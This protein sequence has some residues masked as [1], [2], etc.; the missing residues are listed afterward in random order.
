MNKKE[1][2]AV[3]GIKQTNERWSWAGIREDKSLVALTIWTDQRN[4]G[5]SGKWETS[6]FGMNNPIWKDSPGNNERIRIIKYCIENLDGKFRAIWME[7]E[8]KNVMDAT[9]EY[10]SAKPEKKSWFKIRDFNQ[11]T[12]EFSSDNFDDLLN[13]ANE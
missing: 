5:G 9:R 4:Y 10:I 2:F 13:T 7:P 6:V 12:G 8:K 1:A 11:E 3:F